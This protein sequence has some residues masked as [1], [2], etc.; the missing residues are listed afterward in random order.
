MSSSAGPVR[1]L[2]N[3]LVRQDEAQDVFIKAVFGKKT[4]P[5]SL[6]DTQLHDYTDNGNAFKWLKWIIFKSFFCFDQRC[7]HQRNKKVY[8]CK[9]M[10][11]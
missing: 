7:C 5:S 1:R 10:I 8:S 6:H 11:V 4:D 2:W 3:Y 9:T